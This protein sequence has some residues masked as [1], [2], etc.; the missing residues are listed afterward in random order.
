[1]FVIWRWLWWANKAN[2]KFSYTERMFI[3]LTFIIFTF[4]WLQILVELKLRKGILSGY[5][6]LL[7]SLIRNILSVAPYIPRQICWL[8]L[9]VPEIRFT[10]TATLNSVFLFPP[11]G[12]LTSGCQLQMI[13]TIPTVERLIYWLLESQHWLLL[14]RKCAQNVSWSES[15]RQPRE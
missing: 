4:H 13:V 9:W 15:R 7:Q 1:M 11:T 5:F 2:N 3:L 12:K 10:S 8:E 14:K 6:E